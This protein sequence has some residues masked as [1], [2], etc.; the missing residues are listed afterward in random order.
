M[1][2]DKSS[3]HS[4]TNEC[5]LKNKIFCGE[6]ETNQVFHLNITGDKITYYDARPSDYTCKI[7]DEFS[8]EV[9]PYSILQCTYYDADW[10]KK[11][12][13]EFHMFYF[14]DYDVRRGLESPDLQVVSHKTEKSIRDLFLGYCDPAAIEEEKR[15]KSDEIYPNI[16]Y[17]NERLS[18]LKKN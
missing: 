2:K 17:D 7:I 4:H 12:I 14:S 6:W 8:D 3:A 13:T 5:T 9:H 15:C 1:A 10:S 18:R 16:Y 11:N